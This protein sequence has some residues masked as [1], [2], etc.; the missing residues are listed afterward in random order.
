MT[1][2]LLDPDEG[3]ELRS[4]IIESLRVYLMSDRTGVDANEVFRELGLDV[5]SVKSRLQDTDLS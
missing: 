2:R 3:L 1:Q 4:E 5:S